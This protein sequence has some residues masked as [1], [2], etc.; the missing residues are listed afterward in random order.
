MAEDVGQILANFQHPFGG[1]HHSK[2]RSL[3]ATRS[4]EGRIS[5]VARLMS[6]P[7]KRIGSR[8]D[9]D[10][11]RGLRRQRESREAGVSGNFPLTRSRVPRDGV[12]RLRHHAVVEGQTKER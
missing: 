12:A 9:T 10:V 7:R 1:R 2:Q 4:D 3:Q 6:S 8:Y 11:P 5:P